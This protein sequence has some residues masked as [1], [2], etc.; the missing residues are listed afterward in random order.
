LLAEKVTLLRDFA[1]CLAAVFPSTATVESDVFV[2]EWEKN[3]F[4]SALT[5]WFPDD[6]LY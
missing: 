2:A 6:L 4:R 5:D 3:K 1:G